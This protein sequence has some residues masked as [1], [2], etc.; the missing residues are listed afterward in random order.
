MGANRDGWLGGWDGVHQS[1]IKQ[2]PNQQRYAGT[3]HFQFAMCQVCY[4]SE[5]CI[6]FRASNEQTNEQMCIHLISI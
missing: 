5:V 4:K 6:R 1:E 3:F 2:K